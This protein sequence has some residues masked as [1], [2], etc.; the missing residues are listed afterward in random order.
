M[1]KVVVDV[2]D[3]LWDLNGRIC[4]EYSIDFSNIVSFSISDNNVLSGIDK[5]KLVAGYI[6]ESTFKE[7]E[8]YNGVSNLFDLEKLGA[9]VFINSNSSNSSI[10][11]LK[12]EQLKQVFKGVSDD[13]FILTIPSDSREK[14]IGDNV[15]IFL[16]DSP[17]NIAGCEAEYYI[18]IRKPWNTSDNGLSIMRHKLDKVIFCD[19]FIEAYSIIKNLLKGA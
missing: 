6:D 8:W 19:T 2:D 16:D 11:D 7:I 13:K 18:V 14:D 17:Y 5:K 3:I 9:N 4:Q 12:F 15:F 10:V 1:K